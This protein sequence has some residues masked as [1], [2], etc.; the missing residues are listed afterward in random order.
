[1][2]APLPHGVAL[3]PLTTHADHRGGFTEIFRNEWDT[4]V[5]PIQWNAVHSSTRTLRGVHVHVVHDD[6]LILLQGQA[7]VGLRDLRPDSPT[8]DLA[9]L[10]PLSGQ[11]P[12]A[13]VIPRGVAHGF[14]FLEQSLHVYAVTE[15]WRPDDELGCRWD[16]PDLRIPWPVRDPILSNRDADLGSLSDLV[17]VLCSSPAPLT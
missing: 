16:D 3:R 5:Q 13:L 4:G 1:V 8:R 7:N 9:T 6:Y 10:V 12:Q 2:I 15:Y 14:Y 11:K 17:E